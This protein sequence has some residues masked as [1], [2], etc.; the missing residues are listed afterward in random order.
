MMISNGDSW[1]SGYALYIETLSFLMPPTSPSSDG[2]L[3][4]TMFFEE[5]VK[6]P[7]VDPGVSVT[8]SI[9]QRVEMVLAVET[10]LSA[11]VRYWNWRSEG[12]SESI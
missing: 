7:A 3:M 5:W 4:L 8:I 10:R 9:P 11:G 6:C 1:G 12:D 2:S